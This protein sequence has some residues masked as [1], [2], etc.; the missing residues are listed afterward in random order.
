MKKIYLGAIALGLSVSNAV[1]QNSIAPKAEIS[2]ELKGAPVTNGGTEK[3]GDI[4]WTNNFDTPSDWVIDNDGQS[5]ATFGWTIDANVDGW[6]INSFNSTS[7]GNFAEVGNGDP[8]A[9]PGTQQIGVTYTMTLAAPIDVVNLP[10]NT[11]NTEAVTLTFEQYGARFYD[12]QEVLISTDGVNFSSAYTNN[13]KTIHSTTSNGIYGNPEVVEVNISPYIAGNAST[14]Y[15]QFSWTSMYPTDTSPNAWVTYGWYIDDLKLI[16]N[17]DD[18]VQ[19][20]ASWMVGANNEGIEYGRTPVDQ[21]DAGYYIGGQ[22]FN[23]GAN[24]QTNV[25]LTANFTSFTSNSSQASLNSLDTTYLESLETLPTTPGVY[26]GIYTVVTD[27]EQPGGPD[28]ADNT[29][30]REFEIT[31]A[32]TG[33]SSMYSVDGIGVYNNPVT[34]SLGT[35]SFTGGEDGLVVGAHY[36]IKQA[37]QVSGI[38]VMLA[39]GTDVGS[40]LYGMFIDSTDMW[41]GNILPIFQTEYKIINQTEVNQGY[42]DL[43]FTGGPVTMNPGK[44]YAALEL[45]SNS[46]AADISIVDDETVDQP[47]NASCIYIPQD[48]TYSNGTALGIRLM[49]GSSWLSVGE[50]T[51]TGV[52]IYPNPSEGVITVANDNNV[53]MTIEVIDLVGNVVLTDA[54]SITKELDLTKVASGVYVVKINSNGKSFT[55]NV[56]I[57]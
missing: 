47:F 45:F 50:N 13:N 6:F 22:V 36:H 5:G 26:S 39:S 25:A 28:F 53:D 55:Q 56:V 9:T 4:I 41:A 16:T 19:L 24:T 57:K 54:T 17:P 46:N 34:A 42:A 20:W 44:Y 35:A 15:I 12:Q 2:T 29:G 38:R 27:V 1:A 21:M 23:N 49:M 18:D 14:V 32:S 11:T 7:G 30:A 37:A 8:T 31:E 33:S 51:L 10:L 48:Q 43:L 3:A 40:E 52:S